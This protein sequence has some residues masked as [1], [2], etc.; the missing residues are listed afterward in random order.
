MGPGAAHTARDEATPRHAE[1]RLTPADTAEGRLTLADTAE[2]RLTLADALVFAEGLGA[3]AIVDVA[4]LTGAVVVAL[5]DEYAGEAA[6][7]AERAPQAQAR[8][9]ST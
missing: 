7:R 4:T 8:A 5:G 9:S 6:R 1:G 3:E 2:G